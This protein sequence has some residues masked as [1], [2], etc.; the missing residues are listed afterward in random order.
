MCSVIS[1]T[2][3]R[4]AKS[5]AKRL[6]LLSGVAS[7]ALVSCATRA[8]ST[9]ELDKQA[10]LV[11]TLDVEGAKR[12]AKELKR[13]ERKAEPPVRTRPRIEK[14]WVYGQELSPTVYLQGTHLF[15]EVSPGEWTRGERGVK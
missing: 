15:L 3:I 13:E 5:V 10:G 7:V 1:N 14:I 11:P 12:E 4:Q 8:P 9:F 6:V 2:S